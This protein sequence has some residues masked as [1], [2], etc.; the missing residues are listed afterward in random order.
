[1]K[2]VVTMLA[3]AASLTACALSLRKVIQRAWFDHDDAP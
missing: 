2:R 1:M 3:V